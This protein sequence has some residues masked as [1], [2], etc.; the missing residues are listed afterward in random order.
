MGQTGDCAAAIYMRTFD[1][2]RS[3]A[4]L[5]MYNVTIKNITMGIRP[6]NHDETYDITGSTTSNCDYGINIYSGSPCGTQEGPFAMEIHNSNICGNTEYG[7][8]SDRSDSVILTA[9]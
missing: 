2:Y 9:P 6:G 8:F 4:E 1:W 5:E 7:I 3:Y